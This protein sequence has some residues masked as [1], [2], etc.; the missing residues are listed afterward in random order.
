[1]NSLAMRSEDF[2]VDAVDFPA[3]CWLPEDSPL[4]MVIQ[5]LHVA[6]D[7]AAMTPPTATAPANVGWWERAYALV[8]VGWV[9]IAAYVMGRRL[10]AH[11]HERE[12][13]VL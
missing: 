4:D 5:D 11:A 12:S 8:L 7:Q 3:S 2:L 10:K 9:G 1:M 6:P 13:P